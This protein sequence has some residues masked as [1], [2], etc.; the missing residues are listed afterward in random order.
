MINNNL[1]I[2]I[3]IIFICYYF[4]YNNQNIEN[5]NFRTFKTWGENPFE[6]DNYGKNIELNLFYT[7]WCKYS[8]EFMPMWNKLNSVLKDEP[9][10]L[11]TIDCDENKELCKQNNVNS[12][13]TLILKVNNKTYI[14]NHQRNFYTIILWIRNKI[15]N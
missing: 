3:G 11:N 10:K 12:F 14:Y 1:L 7:K 8:M 15:H 5:A 6:I 9:I 13:P 4:Y 2:A